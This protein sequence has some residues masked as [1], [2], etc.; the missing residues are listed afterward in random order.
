MHTKSLKFYCV[1]MLL[2]LWPGQ[3]ARARLSPDQ[4]SLTGEQIV[5]F[6]APSVVLI[7]TGKG[8]GQ[9]AA[10]GSGL[11]VLSNGALLTAYHLVKDASE[12]QVRLKSGEV[13]DKVELIAFDERRD[14]AA[15]RIQATGLPVIPSSAAPA[16]AHVGKRV[17]ALSNP[18]GLPWTATD[19]I[20]SA[21]RLADDVDGA[22]NGY[23]LLQ[24]TAPVSP[25][26][27]GGVLVDAQGRA[28]GIIVASKSGQNLNFAVP[29]SSIMGLA[30]AQGG[31]SF[32][33][34]SDLQLPARNSP[35][36]AARIINAD[37][38]EL[39]R[40][41]RTIFIHSNTS[42]FNAAQLQNALRKRPEF[43]AWR[44]LIVD[45]W[46]T[47]K[48]AD[49]DIA[50]G[51]PLFTYIF[52]YIV[53]DRRTSIVLATGKVTAFDGNIAAPKLAKRIIENIKTARALP[54]QDPKKP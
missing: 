40:S 38:N 24:F 46:E 21:V 45:D 26:S 37:P 1:A 48:L 41:A 35:P 25:G 15:L 12:V 36:A 52:T 53:K 2:I 34:G 16:E 33:V 17:Y 49:L 10:T 18:Q 22:G 13:Y 23:Q 42:F 8:G 7:L 47:A 43:T 20:L 51:R 32:G 29:L 50:V 28:L 19:G 3:A 54:A 39:L 4:S 9:L 6:V 14:I 27:S 31:T 44:L 30:N 11:I 5:E